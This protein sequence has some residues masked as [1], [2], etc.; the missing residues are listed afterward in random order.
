MISNNILFSI[1]LI[2]SSTLI[3]YFLIYFHTHRNFSLIGQTL[4][5]YLVFNTV[6][7]AFSQV[8]LVFLYLCSLNPFSLLKIEW[9][10]VAPE[11]SLF[12]HHDFLNSKFIFIFLALSLLLLSLIF[13]IGGA[14]ISFWVAR[15]YSYLSIFSLLILTLWYKIALVN[16]LIKIS[17]VAFSHP[18]S[19]YFELLFFIVGFSSF[20]FGSFGAILTNK[21]KTLYAFSSISSLGFLFLSLIV[22]LV[23]LDYTSL[24][25]Y[26]FSYFLSAAIFLFSLFFI[27][28]FNFP[29]SLNSFFSRSSFLF[30]SGKSS[31]F[32]ILL[33]C[34]MLSLTGVPPFLG[35][36]AKFT[37]FSYLA[38]T[39]YWGILIVCFF[40]TLLSFIYYMNFFLPFFFVS[41]IKNSLKM[42]YSRKI[43]LTKIETTTPVYRPTYNNF[44]DFPKNFFI[45]LLFIFCLILILPLLFDFK[46]L[47]ILIED[48]TSS[49][50][51]GGSK[52]SNGE[53]FMLS[54]LFKNFSFK[55]FKASVSTSLIQP[56]KEKFLNKKKEIK[57]FLSIYFLGRLKKD[58][59]VK[60]VR[61]WTGLKKDFELRIKGCFLKRFLDPLLNKV[62]PIFKIILSPPLPLTKKEAFSLKKGFAL[63]NFKKKSTKE[64]LK[65]YF[66]PQFIRY[67]WNYIYYT[68]LTAFFVMVPFFA[69]FLSIKCGFLLYNA[70]VAK[71]ISFGWV[72]FAYYWFV[73]ST[74]SCLVF[75]IMVLPYFFWLV[76]LWFWI[77]GFSCLIKI[78]SVLSSTIKVNFPVLQII[79][80]TLTD[81]D[82]FV[83]TCYLLFIF[84]L[85][86]IQTAYTRDFLVWQG[87]K[88]IMRWA[89]HTRSSYLIKNIKLFFSNP[90]TYIAERTCEGLVTML[91]CFI[92]F[93]TVENAMTTDPNYLLWLRAN[94][95]ERLD[96]IDLLMRSNRSD[97]AIWEIL[98]K[99]TLSLSNEEKRKLASRRTTVAVL[100]KQSNIDQY[101]TKTKRL[102]IMDDSLIKSWEK[103]L[104]PS[105]YKDRWLFDR[106]LKW[107]RS[108]KVEKTFLEDLEKARKRLGLYSSSLASGSDFDAE[109]SS[110]QYLQSSER[111]SDSQLNLFT[112]HVNNLSANFDLEGPLR[113]H[114]VSLNK[115]L[116]EAHSHYQNSI[117]NTANT[118]DSNKSHYKF[119]TIA[120]NHPGPTYTYPLIK[121]PLRWAL[122]ELSNIIFYDIRGFS[123]KQ[124]HLEFKVGKSPDVF[125]PY[126]K[127][128]FLNFIEQ[129][130][131]MPDKTSKIKNVIPDDFSEIVQE[132]K[133]QTNPELKQ[134]LQKPLFKSSSQRL[135]DI[136]A[137]TRLNSARAK[138]D[139]DFKFSKIPNDKES[140]EQ[141]LQRKWFYHKSSYF[142]SIASSS[143]EDPSILPLNSSVN[144][145]Y[146]GS[147]FWNRTMNYNNR[148]HLYAFQP[149]SS[150]KFEKD[151][152]ATTPQKQLR[153]SS[154]DFFPIPKNEFLD[155]WESG[156][157]YKESPARQLGLEVSKNFERNEKRFF[158]NHVL[159]K[160]FEKH[161]T[162]AVQYYTNEDISD[163]KKK[164]Y[165][166][167]L[168]RDVLNENKVYLEKELRYLNTFA[169]VDIYNTHAVSAGQQ[170]EGAFLE[171]SESL[172]NSFFKSNR[173]V[174]EL[175]YCIYS[176]RT[177]DNQILDTKIPK[178]EVRNFFK[179][180]TKDFD[181]LR[182]IKSWQKLSTEFS[183][184]PHFNLD[185]SP[186]TL[187]YLRQLEGT[188]KQVAI[189]IN[190]SIGDYYLE[191]RIDRYYQNFFSDCVEIL[192]KY[193]RWIRPY[194]YQI[195]KITTPLYFDALHSY[196][197]Y[198]PFN[199]S[200]AQYWRSFDSFYHFADIDGYVDVMTPEW[201]FW[202]KHF[203]EYPKSFPSA[204][205]RLVRARPVNPF[206]EEEFNK[207][208]DEGLGDSEFWWNQVALGKKGKRARKGLWWHIKLWVKDDPRVTFSHF[209][210][211]WYDTIS[212]WLNKPKIHF[213]VEDSYTYNDYLEE[214]KRLK[215]NLWPRKQGFPGEIHQDL[216]KDFEHSSP[217]QNRGYERP[218]STNEILLKNELFKYSNLQDKV[219]NQQ[220]KILERKFAEPLAILQRTASDSMVRILAYYASNL[221]R[222]GYL[223]TFKE[224]Y[225]E[226]WRED[227]FG[228]LAQ[229]LTNT[230]NLKLP[231]QQKRFCPEVAD[232]V[233]TLKEYE[234]WFVNFFSENLPK[235]LS[236][237]NNLN[238]KKKS[239]NHINTSLEELKLTLFN[240]NYKVMVRD[241][242]KLKLLVVPVSKVFH[243]TKY[244]AL[245][246]SLEAFW[247]RW[248]YLYDFIFYNFGN[249][250]IKNILTCNN[251]LPEASL[252]PNILVSLLL[253]FGNFS[254]WNTN[255]LK[256][257]NELLNITQFHA[258]LRSIDQLVEKQQLNRY[259]FDGVSTKDCLSLKSIFHSNI[260][261][262]EKIRTPYVFTLPWDERR[263]YFKSVLVNANYKPAT[264]FTIIE[265]LRNAN[266]LNLPEYPISTNVNFKDI[267]RFEYERLMQR[268][269]VNSNITNIFKYTASDVTLQYELFYRHLVKAVGAKNTFLP[270]WRRVF[271]C[272]K[273]LEINHQTFN[274]WLIDLWGKNVAIF[275]IKL[276]FSEWPLQASNYSKFLK[277]TSPG[278][279]K[280]AR[281]LS[282]SDENFNLEPTLDLN[283]FNPLFFGSVFEESALVRQKSKPLL[284]AD[285]V[286]SNLKS[287]VELATKMS[288]SSFFYNKLW[289][290][291]L[292]FAYRDFL[293]NYFSGFSPYLDLIIPFQ[294]GHTLE[295]DL[296][297]LYN[298]KNVEN[299]LLYN[300]LSLEILQNL[301]WKGDTYE[302]SE[303]WQSKTHWCYHFSFL[304][305][306]RDAVKFNGSKEKENVFYDP[307]K[308]IDFSAGREYLKLLI[309][310]GTERRMKL[311]EG[312]QK[313]K[314]ELLKTE[315]PNS[316]SEEHLYDLLNWDNL[317]EIHELMEYYVNINVHVKQVSKHFWAKE[318]DILPEVKK[319]LG[320]TPI[321]LPIGCDSYEE[322]DRAISLL[323]NDP[324]LYKQMLLEERERLNKDLENSFITD[325]I[326]KNLEILD[327]LIYVPG[328]LTKY[329]GELVGI[330]N[331]RECFR[332]LNMNSSI[333][334]LS[335]PFFKYKSYVDECLKGA[336]L[337]SSKNNDFSWQPFK[338]LSFI[339]NNKKFDSLFIDFDQKNANSQGI[340]YET[341]AQLTRARNLL[342][343]T[344]KILSNKSQNDIYT[345]F[346]C[347]KLESFLNKFDDFFKM[348]SQEQFI[349][350]WGF[351]SIDILLKELCSW[352]EVLLKMSDI[353]LGEEATLVAKD[354]PALKST[355]TNSPFDFLQRVNPNFYLYPFLTHP[356]FD[357]SKLTLNIFVNQWYNSNSTF[358]TFFL[359]CYFIDVLESQHEHFNSIKHDYL[360]NLYKRKH[361]HNKVNNFTTY[362]AWDL[363]NTWFTRITQIL[364]WL[365]KQKWFD[366]ITLLYKTL[367]IKCLDLWSPKVM[368]LKPECEYKP[369]W[370]IPTTVDESLNE[371]TNIYWYWWQYVKWRYAPL[372]KT[373][374]YSRDP[375][376]DGRGWRD[377][378]GDTYTAVLPDSIDNNFKKTYFRQHLLYKNNRIG[379]F[380]GRYSKFEDLGNFIT[381]ESNSVPR[382]WLVFLED[383][384][385]MA[386]VQELFEDSF[387]KNEVLKNESRFWLSDPQNFF[388]YTNKNIW[389]LCLSVQQLYLSFKS[390]FI[391]AWYFYTT[392]S[393]RNYIN[394]KLEELSCALELFY[395]EHLV[396]ILDRYI[397]SSF[398]IPESI[399]V[400][401]RLKL[402]LYFIEINYRF[403]KDWTIFPY[404]FK[405]WAE[406]YYY[407]R[408]SLD[409]FFGTLIWKPTDLF[410]DSYKIARYSAYLL[411]RFFTKTH[412][413]MQR[414]RIRD[415]RYIER[416]SLYPFFNPLFS[417]Y[418]LI[419]LDLFEEINCPD[420]LLFR[421][422]IFLTSCF[423]F[424]NKYILSNYIQFIDSIYTKDQKLQWLV[425]K[426]FI[427]VSEPKTFFTRF[428]I[429]IQN[430]VFN[431]K[432]ITWLV[433]DSLVW[434]IYYIF[435]IL[436]KMLK[437]FIKLLLSPFVALFNFFNPLICFVLFIIDRW[438][439]TQFIY[440]YDFES[441]DYKPGQVPKNLLNIWY[442]SQF[443]RDSFIDDE[444]YVIFG[445]GHKYSLPHN[446]LNSYRTFIYPFIS[447]SYE[448]SI[449]LNSKG[450]WDR[451]IKLDRGANKLTLITQFTPKE[452]SSLESLH[453]TANK[454]RYILTKNAWPEN[455][456][457]LTNK[458]KSTLDP[459]SH[460]GKD[461]LFNSSKDFLVLPK[462]AQYF[463][464]DGFYWHF[465]VQYRDTWGQYPLDQLEFNFRKNLLG[466]F[467]EIIIKDP[468]GESYV[469]NINPY[470]SRYNL[471]FMPIGVKLESSRDSLVIK[472]RYG[473]PQNRVTYEEFW[474][475]YR[476]SK[477]LNF[478]LDD[479]AFSDKK[480]V[481]FAF[482]QTSNS[483]VKVVG[484]V[485][486]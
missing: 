187:P 398:Y 426:G 249:H 152:I 151:S 454:G 105:R 440:R 104:N 273:T 486:V 69:L 33:F 220:E 180:C 329:A 362:Y 354:F 229:A 191:K 203:M 175:M 51:T 451:L 480:K 154:F 11:V 221:Q 264:A 200:T 19:P 110:F 214:H 262:F 17:A 369:E 397:I 26:L 34:S 188:F 418:D 373:I 404:I 411:T 225:F 254:V 284:N 59:F 314:S 257:L 390:L 431:L 482:E 147:E 123:R 90:I 456:P 138:H 245:N 377:L 122:K 337:D 193:E 425:K 438:V 246:R 66:N 115:T 429:F 77:D 211:V 341:L 326:K 358:K 350:R 226:A 185:F 205:S 339:E 197:A 335:L 396:P 56:L 378:W 58:L 192:H 304:K 297:E 400:D 385:E 37:L 128:L 265:S 357:N 312:I 412:D 102:D 371:S 442:L 74:L 336:E 409:T 179:C 260:I 15:I 8:A 14:P 444:A 352:L 361:V 12:N 44:F 376:T 149:T 464:I 47:V 386:E 45:N 281:I 318:N 84:M 164:E 121:N 472:F 190:K 195:S 136:D 167:D 428:I 282:G 330:Y 78:L 459:I 421:V 295:D 359:R 348:H 86:T 89:N 216:L 445:C 292:Y 455:H 414:F 103:T 5:N 478:S 1:W 300:P 449:Y 75:P 36:F 250:N 22:S 441:F 344:S 82:N 255:E 182:W 485:G 256:Y 469:Y 276:L 462:W 57:P 38:S 156:I 320:F 417:F 207:L 25:F 363:E 306:N 475:N 351:F 186:L 313:K 403:K 199:K 355:Q 30:T 48:I 261:S 93:L 340:K 217:L 94:S 465:F 230:T 384:E 120:E 98:D 346:V 479:S 272:L 29:I 471:F 439:G 42:S 311:L 35:F 461:Q 372:T 72:C 415:L 10:L 394:I 251:L 21:I 237:V 223:T 28:H 127:L 253:H 70:Y 452:L 119:K 267:V 331:Y 395:M 422:Q 9:Y 210:N 366:H 243:L 342:Q 177:S 213:K 155:E 224:G 484:E 168:V 137:E 124:K 178:H 270:L 52:N 228:P 81:Y 406:R 61:I 303:V 209:K 271:S 238:T 447:W 184:K 446:T 437:S 356:S 161:F 118:V 457:R 423:S 266:I 308:L 287:R 170:E 125:L 309:T 283:W 285:D 145:F 139:P 316:F 380:F 382:D 345:S 181:A 49:I 222:K 402:D 132:L 430:F 91:M 88:H 64:W 63:F 116:S 343:K 427:T 416:S 374:W 108:I 3:A 443:W 85:F 176:S 349:N 263:E 476:K 117:V 293:E 157:H 241:A 96:H 375:L 353:P 153:S 294:T 290:V 381:P 172:S 141:K 347:G 379:K 133:L 483:S 405:E 448:P 194:D 278:Y 244:A 473:L 165:L 92:A 204:Q 231:Y 18:F 73:A 95:S 40:F 277:Y 275:N 173:D 288:Y 370:D 218:N 142:D 332:L 367:L 212:E 171:E 338:L 420:A 163:F 158:Y 413:Y 100:G 202:M 432:A 319:V 424:Y 114:I 53:F 201:Q 131:I 43:V 215:K 463:V 134:K 408:K 435:K 27:K 450:G 299:P 410:P 233:H 68:V 399:K 146:L 2:E 112:K 328:V 477:R 129:E 107:K 387:M 206:S 31:L 130:G 60:T 302:I 111:I 67:T 32:F 453:L 434:I 234:N 46:S 106:E 6:L 79:Y 189:L 50:T 160:F 474:W 39:N 307:V 368:N 143:K 286:L 240:D 135:N 481:S 232:S 470:L 65:G 183:K 166:R 227:I 235:F 13:K 162:S 296:R 321:V 97:K 259:A 280:I 4:F 247:Y 219:I 148:K 101:R 315:D 466:N 16:V 99:P 310:H 242:L 365:S 126:S 196:L 269:L 360:Y 391:N 325:E 289:K 322:R 393:F 268:P 334:K 87:N 23:Y 274:Q 198:K 324:E 333:A 140:I 208:K 109:I 317:M 169:P 41:V 460:L 236:H 364:H 150:D 62:Y 24:Y 458:I 80:T 468:S 252:Y 467:F 159:H 258:D 392:S 55:R 174:G 76:I 327:Y 389:F 433:L 323:E 291:L 436:T 248:L 401:E 298:N 419:L 83:L 388:M 54:S 383:D 71:T 305:E 20:V 301:S 113:D 239:P 407:P 144:N 7:F 279:L